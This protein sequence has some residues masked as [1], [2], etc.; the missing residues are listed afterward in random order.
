MEPDFKPQKRTKHGFSNL[1]IRW[2]DIEAEK[3]NVH[4]VHQLNSKTGEV[5]IGSS[6]HKVD[7]F[8]A[9]KNLILEMHGCFYHACRKCNQYRME[10]VHPYYPMTFSEVRERTAKK[11]QYFKDLG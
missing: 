2:L 11:I 3:R 7:R 5:R 4:I 8:C 1:A 9:E 10:Q 6:K